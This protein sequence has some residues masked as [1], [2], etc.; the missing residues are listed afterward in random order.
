MDPIKTLCK[1]A[2]Y[3]PEGIHEGHPMLDDLTLLSL[4]SRKLIRPVEIT[5]TGMI[6]ELTASGWDLSDSNHKL[7]DN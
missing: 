7:Y 3:H 5:R 4:K 2:D 1:I 6:Y